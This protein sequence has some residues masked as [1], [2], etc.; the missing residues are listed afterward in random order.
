MLT[1]ALTYTEIHLLA[2]IVATG[3]MDPG[4]VR[5]SPKVLA[6]ARRAGREAV[7]AKI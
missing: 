1:D 5:G 3:V 7:V 2:T 4:D 6:A